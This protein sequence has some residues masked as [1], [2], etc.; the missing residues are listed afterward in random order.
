MTDCVG[1]LA[2]EKL[3]PIT[4][5]DQSSDPE[6]QSMPPELGLKNRD[7]MRRI[8]A[9]ISEKLST[10]KSYEDFVIGMMAYFG[11]LHADPSRKDI[12]DAMKLE[13]AYNLILGEI[14]RV[15]FEKEYND[16]AKT[17]KI[18]KLVTGVGRTYY[19]D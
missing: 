14:H 6:E 4:A 17:T 16:R 9:E 12:L 1:S 5:S 13:K 15:L 3:A 7:L 18:M 10:S 8:L 19:F 2:E 11:L